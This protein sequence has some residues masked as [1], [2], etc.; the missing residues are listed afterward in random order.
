MKRLILPFSLLA[1]AMDTSTGLLLVI[2]PKWT[3]SLLA[4]ADP[5]PAG[6]VYLGW[7]GVFVTC[8]GL[9]Y[10]LCLRGA[11]AAETVWTFT[12][13]VRSGVALFLVGKIAMG[14]LPAAWLTVAMVDALVAIIQWTGLRA[15][16][17]R[18]PEP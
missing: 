15:R 8:V 9:S 3:L 5:D 10:A 7:I 1:G 18:L 13:V 16:W 17:W 2:S 11:A 12:A 4:I 6:L 14:E